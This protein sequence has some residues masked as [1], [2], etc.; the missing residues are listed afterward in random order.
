MKKCLFIAAL[1]L[2]SSLL[3]SQ[4]VTVV[5]KTTRQI[6]PGVVMYSDN[7]KVSTTTNAKGQAD[8]FAFR[9][10][11]SIYF[12]HISYNN[13]DVFR[14]VQLE[15]RQFLIELTETYISL[16]EVV[17]TVNRW[18]EEQ[19]EIP[20]RV[21]K[22]SLKDVSFQNP[23]T[24]ADLLGNSGYAFIQKSQLSGGSPS[25]RGFATNRIMLVVD[26]I[27]M[28]NAIFRTGNLQNVVSIDAYSLESTEILFGPGAVMYGSDAIGG[29]M[30][31]HTFQPI[32]SDS[33]ENML[34]TGNTFMRYA[35]A[36]SVN[37]AF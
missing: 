2:Y 32:L 29:V 23:Q 33:S 18:E 25:L 26:G 27:R 17:V 12:R 36:S 11:D 35:S 34:I 22:I 28:N 13:S 7:P 37:W 15:S 16:N 4:I 24:A 5:D 19:I 21:E 1:T 10:A 20:Y 3:F 6:I 8:I 30:D 9:G 14:F 31:F